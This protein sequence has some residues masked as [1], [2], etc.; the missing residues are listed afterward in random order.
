MGKNLVQFHKRLS[1]Q[2]CIIKRSHADRIPGGKAGYRE[3][4]TAGKEAALQE[5]FDAGFAQVGVPLGRDLGLLRGMASAVI[6][7]LKST[8]EPN[9]PTLVE[10]Q[11]IAEQLAEVRFSDIAPRDLEAEAHAREHLEAYG[12][13]DE[14]VDIPDAVKDKR[15]VESLEDMINLL[16]TNGNVPVKSRPTMDDIHALKGRLDALYRA[17]AIKS[18]LD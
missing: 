16:N 17:L 10:A 11:N 7:V 14:E 6:A 18:F 5:G 15:D 12:A 1:C 8:T 4:I 2:C 3:G 13:P 9:N